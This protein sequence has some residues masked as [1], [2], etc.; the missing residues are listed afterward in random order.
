MT[1]PVLNLQDY[2]FKQV[3]LEEQYYEDLN[4]RLL[5]LLSLLLD[6]MENDY[7]N[8]AGVLIIKESFMK[9]YLYQI[10]PINNSV[11]HKIQNITYSATFA[12]NIPLLNIIQIVNDL[13]IKVINLI[14]TIVGRFVN[15][16]PAGYNGPGTALYDAETTRQ[17]IIDRYNNSLNKYVQHSISQIISNK[18]KNNLIN[19]GYSEYLSDNKHDDRVRDIHKRDNDGVTW[20]SFDNLPEAGFP[21]DDWGCRCT[22]IAAR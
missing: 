7:V 19:M 12:D 2:L 14:D 18:I 16:I 13:N 9:T 21:G 20:H 22:I 8:L 10:N 3:E 6:Y 15:L 11:A 17:S 1:K 5:I 4:A